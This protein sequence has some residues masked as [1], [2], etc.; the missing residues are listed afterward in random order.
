MRYAMLRGVL[1]RTLVRCMAGYAIDNMRKEAQNVLLMCGFVL[2]HWQ[3]GSKRHVFKH[4][5]L[6]TKATAPV[7]AKYVTGGDGADDLS[8]PAAQALTSRKAGFRRFDMSAGSGNYQLQEH[9]LETSEHR[10]RKKSK[11]FTNSEDYLRLGRC[12]DQLR[13]QA[14]GLRLSSAPEVSK[15]GTGENLGS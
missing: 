14:I 7:T 12:A 5:P 11:C 9:A 4:T 15:R 1:S 6:G 10:M 2:L 3:S 13:N 8:S